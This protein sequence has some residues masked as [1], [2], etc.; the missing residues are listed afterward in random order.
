[1]TMTSPYLIEIHAALPRVLGLFNINPI[2]VLYGVGDRYRW[3]WK[4]SDFANGTFQSAAHGLALLV[5]HRLLP[6]GMDEGSVLNRIH[7]MIDGVRAITRRNGSLDEI[8]PL[9][10]SY[11][12]TALVAFEMLCA[13]DTLQERLNDTQRQ[14]HL[15]SIAPLIHFLTRARESHGVITNHLAVAAAALTRWQKMT[16]EDVTRP[17]NALIQNILQHHSEEGWFREYEGADPGYQTLAL[18]YLAD[19]NAH[20]PELAL[21]PLLDK[22]C[23]F[24]TYCAHPD[25]S[26]GGLY[27]SRNTRFLY[28]A[29]LEQLAQTSS[30]ASALAAF[31]RQAHT[32][33]TTVGLAAMDDPNLIPMFT[34]FCRA[35]AGASTKHAE[36]TP[37]PHARAEPFQRH[38]PMAGWIIT[39][40]PHD[41]SIVNWRKSTIHYVSATHQVCDGGALASDS[42]QRWFTSQ[43]A[44]EAARLIS[45]DPSHI[46]IEASLVRYHVSFPTPLNMVVLRL[47]CVSVMRIPALNA[48]IKQLLVWL[49]V[50]RKPTSNNLVRRSITLQPTLHIEDSWIK[51]PARLTLSPAPCAFHATH[52]ASQG[53]WQ[54]GDD[55]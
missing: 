17:R 34:S 12:V 14:R 30:H 3:A 26:F 49:L 41:Y 45:A 44:G 43:T 10:S 13:L 6:D 42:N 54:H 35:A 55:R 38:F 48:L 52:M 50:S 23:E 21:Q 22:A 32:D 8:L 39:K 51:N 16:G 36:A 24:L 29:G 19:T 25:G 37:L 11:C 1:M 9:E 5:Q 47:L 15:D 7:A 46:V 2:S 28:P 40:N 53:Y 4:G 31:A 33:K 27:G 18:D 20:A